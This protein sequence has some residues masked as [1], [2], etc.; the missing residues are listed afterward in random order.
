MRQIT[1]DAKQPLRKVDIIVGGPPCQAFA[2]VGRAKL[3][4]INAHPEAFLHDERS[5]LYRHYL[6]YVE[7]LAPVAV[8]VENVPDVLNYGGLNVFETMSVALE[9]AGYECRYSLL[10]A[11]HYGVPQMR[12]RCFLVAIHRLAAVEPVLPMPTHKHELPIRVLCL[13]NGAIPSR[14]LRDLPGSR[15]WPMAA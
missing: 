13:W 6:Q 12:T 15:A 9:E 2:R 4:E 8:I 14:P 3:R 11:A 10:N 1:P 7:Q 5:G